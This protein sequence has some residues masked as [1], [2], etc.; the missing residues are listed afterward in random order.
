MTYIIYI[1]LKLEQKTKVFRNKRA[2]EV[3]ETTNYSH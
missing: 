2:N 3:Q 1:T